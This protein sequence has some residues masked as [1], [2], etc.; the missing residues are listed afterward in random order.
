MNKFLSKKVIGYSLILFLILIISGGIL[1][2][3]VTNLYVL[4]AVL[5]IEYIVLLLIVFHFF[6]KYVKPIDKAKE[7]MD[8]LLK[9]NYHARIHQPMTGSI[10]ELST[11]INSLA[12]SLSE[13]TISEQI[14]AEQLSTVIENSESGLVLIDEK[15]YIHVVN[16]KFIS[17]FGKTP[18]DYIGYLYYDVLENEQIHHTV[19]ETFLYEKHVKHLFSLSEN[20]EQIYLEIVGAP[21]FNERNMLKGAVLVI[22]DIT[23]FKNIE[24]MRRDFV[25]NVSHELKTPITSIKGFAETLLDGA[26]DDPEALDQFLHI[27]FEESKRIQLLIDD[28]L[29]LS[30]LEKDESTINVGPVEVGFVLDDILPVINQHAEQ[31]NIDIQVDADKQLTFEAD[32]EKI[33]QILLNLLTNAISYTPEKGTVSLKIKESED[34]VCLQVQDT[35]IGISKEALP[36]IFERFYRVDKDRSRDTGG[37][38]LGLAIVKHIVEVHQGEIT[39]ESELGKGT[40]FS[41]LVPKEQAK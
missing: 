28:L 15:G 23:E 19:Q 12:R 20:E 25:A 5:V 34:N 41:V 27:I 30:K 9:G 35:G 22:Y 29:I 21:I 39:V 16:R 10:G 24:V 8:K 38:G 7:T 3:V 1:S 18:Q 17:M 2:Q 26:A 11:K 32:E 6:D 14:Q 37:T 36:R 40:T 31:K 4:L 13:L 33:K